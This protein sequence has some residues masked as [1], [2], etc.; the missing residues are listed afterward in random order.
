[1]R[2]AILAGIIRAGEVTIPS[3]ED[4]IRAGDKVIVVSSVSGL[5]S[6]DEVLR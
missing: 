1:M 4:E 5:G 3:G 2:G 6:F